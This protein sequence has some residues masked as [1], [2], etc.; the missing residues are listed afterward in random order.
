MSMYKQGGGEVDQTKGGG[1]KKKRK[2][3]TQLKVDSKTPSKI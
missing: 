3:S 2:W 1:E